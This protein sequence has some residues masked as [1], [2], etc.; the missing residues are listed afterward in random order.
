MQSINNYYFTTPENISISSNVD[1]L[2]INSN[3]VHIIA[4]SDFDVTGLQAPFD[5]DHASR[6]TL[7]NES[8]AGVDITLKA[9]DAGS[10]IGNRFIMAGDLVLT[11]GTY[12]FFIKVGVG[13]LLIGTTL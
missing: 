7:E 12:A 6:V 9:N 2:E 1:N 5:G 8:G 13:F 4:S 11:P 3:Y 10:N